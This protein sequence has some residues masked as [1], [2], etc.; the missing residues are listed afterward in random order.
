MGDRELKRW[1]SDQLHSVVGFS[2]GHLAD[3]VVSLARSAKSS[4]A[5]LSKLHEAD[6]PKSQAAAR[7]A[8]E[9]FGRAPKGSGSSKQADTEKA[10]RR[11][12]VS[13]LQQ[14]AQYGFVDADGDEDDGGEAEVTAAV[15]KQLQERERERKRA[16][17]K[18][19]RADDGAASEKQPQ[20]QQQG[21]SASADAQREQDLQ[22]RDEFAERLRQRDLERTRKIAAGPE[23]EALARRQ[24]EAER[25][26]AA[27]TAEEKA[28]AL[29]EARKVSRRVYLE[30]REKKMLEAARDDIKDDEY[31]FGD[32]ELSARERADLEYKKTVYD[33]ANQRVNMSDQVER[34]TMPTAYDA[35]GSVDQG[36]R[37][38]GLLARYQDEEAEEMNEFQAWDA[39]QIKRSTAKVGAADKKAAGGQMGEGAAAYEL[40]MAAEEQIDFIKDE[41]RDGTL[42]LEQ[43]APPKP[44]TQQ[45]KLADVRKT[46]P[47]FAYREEIIAAV[48]EHQVLIIVGETGSGKTTQVPQYLY[49]AGLCD[50]N[51]KIGCTQP[52]RVAAMSVAARVAQE[53]GCKLGNEVGYSIRFEDCTTERTLLKYMTDGMLLREF[54]GEPD[55]ASYSCMM[56]DEA[57]ERTLHTDI[58]FGLLK[59]IARFRPDL[60]LLVSSATLDAAKFSEYFDDAPVFNIP[61]RRFPVDIMYT[62]APEADYLEACVITVLQIHITQP[63]GDILVFFT[64]QDEIESAQEALQQRTRGFGTKSIHAQPLTMD[65]LARPY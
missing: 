16:E 65:C 55:L 18:R 21:V 49:E 34:Y 28:A 25:L 23:A 29:A 35:E 1:V 53:V 33:L 4:A 43:S 54:L 7:F 39:T 5:L 51:K 52:R 22:E 42:T 32:V 13:L 37:F 47:V 30:Q 44:P 45:Q 8:A 60:K 57:H 48:Q 61:G 17:R 2:E 14:N 64:G 24:E 15:Q 46:L 10:Q 36:K 40:V 59:D 56:L 3:Y 20:E 6:V 26:L 58:L 27:G 31:L 63:H 9:L 12:T 50:G 62:K 41:I 19:A 38:E 11:E